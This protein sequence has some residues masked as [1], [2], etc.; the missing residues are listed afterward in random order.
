MKIGQRVI[1]RKA[2]VWYGTLVV[3]VAAIAAFGLES[4][5]GTS[6]ASPGTAREVTVERGTVQSSVSASGNVSAATSDNVDFAT[7][8]TLTAVDVTAGQAVTAGQV[9]GTL[10]PTDAQAA[11]TSAQAS[12]SAAQY[13]LTTAEQGGTT[14]QLEQDQATMASAKNQLTSDEEQLTND[15]TTLT[16]AQNDLT[17]DQALGCPGSTGSGSSS[18]GGSESAATGG[19]DTALTLTGTTTSGASYYFLYGTSTAYGNQTPTETASSQGA[20]SATVTGLTPDTTYLYVLVV[21]GVEGVPQTATT[22]Q[23]SCVVEQQ[24]ITTDEQTVAKDKAT[25]AAQQISIDATTAGQAV[26]PSTVAQDQ[27]QVLQ[28]QNT[29]TADQKALNETTLTAPISGTVTAVNDA[30]GDTVSGGGSSSDAGDSSSDASSGTG[31]SGTGSSGTGSSGTGSSGFGASSAASDDSSSDDSSSSDSSSFVTIENLGGLEVVAGYAE[32]DI[33]KMAVGQTATITL[34]ALPDSTV[35]GTVTAVSPTSTVVSDVVTYDVTIALENPPAT[36]K[37]GMTA[38]VSVVVQTVSNTLEL[39]S[40]AITTTGPISTVTVL[41]NGVKK[42]TTVTTGVVG[43]STTQIESGLKAGETVV[44]PEA[45]VS[46]STGATT[47]GGFGG[48]TGGGGF[49]GFGGGGFGRAG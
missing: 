46:A 49:G 38:D 44:E 47:T 5:Y 3:A 2:I 27:A 7:S 10:D 39:P 17:S 36:V 20:A 22:A 37:V 16:D 40:A 45:S 34:P 31:S 12:L 13:T 25:I 29:V 9:L 33:A 14:A 42:V 1:Q 43:D 35:T 6:S 4:I 24:A 41:A 11:L 18:G 32:A 21:G 26:V 19:S 48:L 28:D 30:V 15:E 23:S 8:G